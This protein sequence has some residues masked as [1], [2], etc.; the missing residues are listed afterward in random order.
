M[1]IEKGSFVN[2]KEVGIGR[3]KTSLETFYW[4]HSVGGCVRVCSSDGRL[5]HR[6]N[7]STSVVGWFL[8]GNLGAYLSNDT[9]LAD[10]RIS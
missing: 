7:M 9:E 8:K 2:G 4:E 6:V 1:L 3:G 5:V 10:H